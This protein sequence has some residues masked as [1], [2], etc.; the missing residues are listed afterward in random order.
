[1]LLQPHFC[2]IINNPRASLSPSLALFSEGQNRGAALSAFYTLL[3]NS[4]M[5]SFL[6]LTRSLSVGDNIALALSVASTPTPLQ[7][8]AMASLYSLCNG[9][10]PDL[11]EESAGA[12]SEFWWQDVGTSEQ[13]LQERSLSFGGVSNA[14]NSGGFLRCCSRTFAPSLTTLRL[15]S[16]LH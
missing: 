3:S 7:L 2:T 1:M 6:T 11:G 13:S 15:R 16:H 8:F 14:L 5:V 9:A 12:F 4:G 10:W